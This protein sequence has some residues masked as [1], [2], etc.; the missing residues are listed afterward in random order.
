MLMSVVTF[1]NFSPLYVVYAKKEFCFRI[2]PKN[3][4]FT[5]FCAAVGC[6]RYFVYFF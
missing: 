6:L 5:L 4:V 3:D 1:R 2:V